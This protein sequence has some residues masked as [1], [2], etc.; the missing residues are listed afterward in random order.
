MGWLGRAEST[1]EAPHDREALSNRRLLEIDIL[2]SRRFCSSFR[3]GAAHMP[4]ACRSQAAHAAPIL[5]CSLPAAK[6]QVP[7]VLDRER[8]TD[9]EDEEV[10]GAEGE[11]GCRA[12]D[13]VVVPGGQARRAGRSWP[14]RRPMWVLVSSPATRGGRKT[15]PLDNRTIFRRASYYTR[16]EI[17]STKSCTGA[18]AG[19]LPFSSQ[20]AQR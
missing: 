4:H 5:F 9:V 12:L 16:R 11:G 7:G 17:G 19:H 10:A 18:R 6:V 14:I 3:R 8:D 20:L 2:L 13:R 1:R 15:H